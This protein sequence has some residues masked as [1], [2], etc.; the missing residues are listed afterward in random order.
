MPY[1]MATYYA[2][3][4]GLG[5]NVPA[6]WQH[7]AT[8]GV[9]VHS[10]WVALGADRE[11]NSATTSVIVFECENQAQA[12]AYV[13]WLR[14]FCPKIEV[15]SVTD[16]MPNIQNYEAR[17]IVNWPVGSNLTEDQKRAA[18]EVIQRYMD[19]PS[20]AEAIRIYLETEPV[21]GGPGGAQ[22]VRNLQ[23]AKSLNLD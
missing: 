16:Y 14:P 18:R 12:N 5:P 17:D 20:P 7:G 6:R 22:L 4:L 3:P 2:G 15:S 11:S 19:A 8:P 10:A 23:V 13:N 1:Y 21:P 9:K